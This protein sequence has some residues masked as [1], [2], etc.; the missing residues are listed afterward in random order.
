MDIDSLRR[1]LAGM[2]GFM[3]GDGCRMA[4]SLGDLMGLEVWLQEFFV[5]GQLEGLNEEA[6]RKTTAAV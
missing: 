2:N 1:E 3:N 4:W 6:H 5:R